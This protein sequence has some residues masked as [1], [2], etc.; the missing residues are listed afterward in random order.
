MHNSKFQVHMGQIVHVYPKTF[1][2]SC[3]NVYILVFLYVQIKKCGTSNCKGTSLVVPHDS[4]SVGKG[5][6]T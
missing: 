6:K 2:I 3:K 1:G 4:P 5:N